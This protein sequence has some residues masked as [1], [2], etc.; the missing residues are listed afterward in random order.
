MKA[1][2]EGRID[3]LSPGFTAQMAECLDCRACEAACPSGVQYGALIEGM[4]ERIETVREPARS[5]LQRLARRLL[6]HGLFGNAA[7]MRAAAGLLRFAQ[8]TRLL[9]LAPLVGLGEPA[10]LA[11]QIPSRFFLADDRRADTPA[12][13]GLAFLHCGCV[14]PVVYPGIHDATIRMLKRARLNVVVPKDQGCCGAIA[15]H[16]GD[17]V[18]ARVLAQRNIAAFERSGADVYVV[19]AAGCGSTLKAYPRLFQDDA[20]WSQRAQRFSSRVRDVLEVLDAVELDSHIGTLHLDVTYQEPCHLVHAQGISAAPRRLLA[21][22]PGLRLIE[23]EE[24]SVCCGGAGVY[25]LTQP[26]MSRRLER[27]KTANIERT[28][29]RVVATANPGCAMQVAAGLRRAGYQAEVKHIVEIL[30]RAY[31]G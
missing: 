5:P 8:Q 31:Q 3:L 2:G 20:L 14:T 1:V 29:A 19:N 13:Q 17:P 22:I 16:A 26:E 7:L 18:F 30:D 27:R 24:S 10:R 9:S 11:P 12:A 15:V 28:A 6:L 4:R 23:M 21:R 25:N